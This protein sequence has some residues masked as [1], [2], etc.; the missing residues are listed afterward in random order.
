[1][2]FCHDDESYIGKYLITIPVVINVPIK[3]NNNND[4]YWMVH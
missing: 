2:V 1:M 4:K 3:K